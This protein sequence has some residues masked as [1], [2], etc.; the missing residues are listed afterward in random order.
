[1][2]SG[3]PGNQISSPTE[4]RT[5]EPGHIDV[6]YVLVDIL[7][8]NKKVRKLKKVLRSELETSSFYKT[9][10]EFYKIE[11]RETGL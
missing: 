3:W 8:P 10:I 5:F 9:T 2:F 11:S 1:M 4:V 7:P 6:S